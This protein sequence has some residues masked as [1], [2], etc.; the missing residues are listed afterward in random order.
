MPNLYSWGKRRPLALHY[1]EPHTEPSGDPMQTEL[2]NATRYFEKTNPA[3]GE[4]LAHYPVTDKAAVLEAEGR[5]CKA[6]TLWKDSTAGD[7]ARFLK[8]LADKLYA[9]TDEA[10]ATVSRETGKPMGDAIQAD[11]ATAINVLNYYADCG[12]GLLAPKILK[13]D[14]VSLVTGRL[15]IETRHPHGIV[16]IITPWNYPLAITASGL[17]VTLMAGNVAIVKPSELAPQ[18][19]ELLVRLAREVLLELGLPIDVVQIVSGDGETGAALVDANLDAAIFTGSHT[20]G[21]KVLASL[22]ARNK[23]VSLELGGSDP[24]IILDSINDTDLESAAA[25]AVWGRFV[26]A[27][28]ACAAVKRLFVPESKRDQL[29]NLLKEKI[30]QLRVGPPSDETSQVGPLISGTQRALLDEQ[31]KDALARGA[32]LHTGGKPVDGPGFFYELTLMTDVPAEARLLTEEAFGPVLPVI[33]Y[34]NLDDAIATAN[35]SNYGLTASVFGP[36]D[37]ARKVADRLDCGTVAINDVGT[38]N[39]AMLCAGWGGWKS[40]GSGTSHGQKAL[41]E[42]TRTKV[43]TSNLLFGLPVLGKPLWHFSKRPGRSGDA[44]VFLDLACMKPGM[45]HPRTLLAFWHNRA[46]TK[47]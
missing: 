43:V 7:R 26:N 24:M 47:I 11:V 37:E 15:H 18:T 9:C 27:G 30:A 39:Y 38:S 46:E 45:L 36:M 1:N 22:G 3:T 5:G 34:R 17:A 28:Q 13:P 29:V 20:T 40:S 21:S 41:L 12:P 31:V 25:Y 4:I 6:F 32:T 44:K 16:G 2:A 14:W 23:W 10:A 42:M 33:A 35:A 8:A 19:G